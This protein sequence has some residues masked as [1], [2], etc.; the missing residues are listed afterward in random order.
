MRGYSRRVLLWLSL[1]V[2]LLALGGSIVFAV[3]C[4]LALWRQLKSTGG[5]IGDALERLSAAADA[6]AA[7]ADALGGASDRLAEALANLSA[8]RAR[9]RVLQEAWS[10]VGA[11]VGRVSS[12]LPREKK[13]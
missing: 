6:T 5:A 10:D 1:T 4:W 13:A 9:L 11:S 2:A 7:R 12:Y 3:R 8:S